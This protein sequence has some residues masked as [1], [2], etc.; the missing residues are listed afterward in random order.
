[1]TA[2]RH[3]ASRDKRRASVRL[4]AA[5]FLWLTCGDASQ[6]WAQTEQIEYYALDAIGSVRVVFDQTGAV[7][8][9]M[10]Y[11]PFGE[12]LFSGLFVPADRF[13]QLSRDGEAGLDYAQARMY[14]P[15]TGRLNAPDLVFA[16]LTNP[17]GWNRY[18]YGLSNPTGYVDPTGLVNVPTHGNC[19]NPN[20]RVE[21][22]AYCAGSERIFSGIFDPQFARQQKG[23]PGGPGRGKPKDPD[24]D[25]GPDPGPKPP[26]LGEGCGPQQNSTVIFAAVNGSAAVGPKGKEYNAGA[27]IS[28]NSAFMPFRASG[29]SVGLGGGLSVQVGVVRRM[30]NFQGRS[31]VW[32]VGFGPVA[33]SVYF[34][35]T[36]PPNA[37]PTG[38]SFG[39][40]FSPG[41]YGI[42]YS[43]MTTTVG[44]PVAPHPG[45]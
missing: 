27:A 30:A 14:Q 43:E 6:L 29:R 15:R 31:N 32:N 9:R 40:G 41:E 20:V 28:R 3:L 10:D 39:L 18:S 37:L 5:M 8:G 7:K 34:D 22:P 4:I 24:K 16:G 33:I 13:A 1:V 26:P 35:P 25:P 17:Q 44:R 2:P 23:S 36:K 19:N 45:C 42:S 11:A 21:F 38:V 12:E